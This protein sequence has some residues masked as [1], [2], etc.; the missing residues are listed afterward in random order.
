MNK[1]DNFK[2]KV[3]KVFSEQLTDKVFLMIQ[4]DRDLMREY[5]AVIEKSKSLANVNSEIA[6]EVKK[7]FKLKN[8]NQKNKSPESFLIQGHEMFEAE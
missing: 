8:L 1:L 4:N 3:I 7:R 5:L 2:K 6:K